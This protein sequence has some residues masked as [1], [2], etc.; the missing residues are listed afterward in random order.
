MELLKNEVK[1]V[2]RSRI[3]NEQLANVFSRVKK[4]QEYLSEMYVIYLNKILAHLANNPKLGAKKLSALLVREKILLSPSAIY[5]LLVKHS[6][7]SRTLRMAWKNNQME[8]K[9]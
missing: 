2:K 4:P 6:L 9:L 7:N 5:K 3:A 8:I 1:A